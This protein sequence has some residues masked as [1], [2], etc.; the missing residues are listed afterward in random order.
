MCEAFGCNPDDRYRF[1]PTDRL[2]DVYRACYPRWKF[3]NVG[4]NME[5][6][7]LMLELSRKF[8]V[9]DEDWSTDITLGEIIGMMQSALENKRNTESEE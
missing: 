4:D 2:V 5:I 6:E 9:D 8:S 1:A 7:S 3:W